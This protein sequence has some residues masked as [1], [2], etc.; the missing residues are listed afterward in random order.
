MD[1]FIV[2]CEA[3]ETWGGKTHHPTISF[4]NTYEDAERFIR[5]RLSLS[6]S[7]A[8]K[9]KHIWG[10]RKEGSNSGDWLYRAAG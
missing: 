6:G 4:Y 10:I 8:L 9:H 1:R 7:I 3:P 5:S 2:E